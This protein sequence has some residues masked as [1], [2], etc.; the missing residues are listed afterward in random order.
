MFFIFNKK[1]LL[2][3]IKIK[4]LMQNNQKKKHTK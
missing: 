3:K 1:H 4:K 2:F